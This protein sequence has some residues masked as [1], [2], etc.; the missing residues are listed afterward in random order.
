VYTVGVVHGCLVG[1]GGCAAL[2]VVVV[3][4]GNGGLG[5]WLKLH[6]CASASA[7]CLAWVE[8]AVGQGSAVT[9]RSIEARHHAHTVARACSRVFSL[10]LCTRIRLYRQPESGL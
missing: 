8:C 5:V 6:G 9:C 10:L 7:S 2:V 3:L 4:L 1:G